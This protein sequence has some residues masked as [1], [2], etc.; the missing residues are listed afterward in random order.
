VL[1]AA[2]NISTWNAVVRM[3]TAEVRFDELQ[4]GDLP[5]VCVQ[6]GVPADMRARLLLDSTPGWT[7]ILLLCGIVPFLIAR[8]FVAVKIDALIPFSDA[9]WKVH[10]RRMRTA[11]ATTVV[12]FAVVVVGV[13]GARG[14]LTIAGLGAVAIGLVALWWEATPVSY[15]ID[16][17]RRVVRLMGVHRRFAEELATAHRSAHR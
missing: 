1:P 12:G 17:H 15:E 11:L 6:T 10:R 16:N 14:V 5:P 13:L 7:W 4:R 9:A 2:T 3:A 8:Y